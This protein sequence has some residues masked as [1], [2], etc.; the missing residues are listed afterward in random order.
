MG[1]GHGRVRSSWGVCILW[2]SDSH[3]DILAGLWCSLLFDLL[4]VIQS[5][6]MMR[7]GSLGVEEAGEVARGLVSVKG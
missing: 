2:L 7:Q 5:L 4:R 3:I 6:E 1:V